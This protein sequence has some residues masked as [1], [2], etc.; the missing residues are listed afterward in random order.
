MPWSLLLNLLLPLIIKLLE[1]LLSDKV[2]SLN[3]NERKKL[4]KI[5]NLTNQLQPAAR[6]FG[7][8]LDSNEVKNAL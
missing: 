4:A 1:Y 3:K 7:L 5:L 6:S 2:E 8:P